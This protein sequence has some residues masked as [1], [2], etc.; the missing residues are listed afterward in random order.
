MKELPENVWARTL[1]S[2]ETVFQFEKRINVRVDGRTVHRAKFSRSLG[3]DRR[4]VERRRLLA[5]AEY[6]RER[7][8]LEDHY[9]GR[10][11]PELVSFRSFALDSYF[12]HVFA[13]RNSAKE[14]RTY[15]SRFEAYVDPVLGDLALP[16]VRR[17]DVSDVLPGVA[18]LSAST[19]R[20]VMSIVRG[21]LDLAE[22]DG[23]IERT[24]FRPRLHLPKVRRGLPRP[25]LREQVEALLNAEALSP[26]H[27]AFVM[28]ALVSGMRR[29]EI[30][31]LRRGDVDWERGVVRVER[32]KGGKDRNVPLTPD[33]RSVLRGWLDE[34]DRGNKVRSVSVFPMGKESF[35]WV[36]RSWK[37]VGFPWGLHLCRHTFAC[38][39]LDNG[40][41]FEKLSAILGHGDVRTTMIYGQVS[42]RAVAAEAMQVVQGFLGAPH[43][44]PHA[45][46]TAQ[47]E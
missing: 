30:R 24:P 44:A 8:R 32:G 37:A 20:K 23:L 19:Q 17:Q 36:R 34:S 42:N 10:A 35:A 25:L 1:R 26:M 7:E 12:P 11:A 31:D 27:R 39:Y 18:C 13:P 6:R 33:L 43:G 9:H 21:V 2:G 5:L 22:D 47:G 16:D 4:D 38:A 14:L 45:H 40:G 41:S 15:M 28:V 29:A 3:T 46:P